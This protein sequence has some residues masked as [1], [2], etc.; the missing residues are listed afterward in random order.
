MSGSE[1]VTLLGAAWEAVLKGRNTGQRL[2]HGAAAAR[3]VR[4]L[5]RLSHLGKQPGVAHSVVER[6]AGAYNGFLA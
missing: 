3:H 2:R 5:L 1:A 4:D 6:H